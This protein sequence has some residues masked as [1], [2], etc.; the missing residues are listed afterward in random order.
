MEDY[1]QRKQGVEPLDIALRKDLT[2]ME[3]M[4]LK[5]HEVMEIRGKVIATCKFMRLFLMAWFFD[6]CWVFASDLKKP[7]ICF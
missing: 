3:E 2:K 6:F 7:I 4:L 1:N 5:S